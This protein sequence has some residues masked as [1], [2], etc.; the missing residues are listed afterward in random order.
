MQYITY[1]GPAENGVYA[2]GSLDFIFSV[3]KRNGSNFCV[4][5]QYLKVNILANT[6]IYYLI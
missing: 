4:K 3:V 5:L 1:R 6:Y 2:K